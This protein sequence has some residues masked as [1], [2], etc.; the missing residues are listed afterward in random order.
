M[1]REGA[2]RLAVQAPTFFER[3]ARNEV[4][5]AKVQI[6][7]GAPV[8]SLIGGQV[9]IDQRYKQHM[10]FGRLARNEVRHDKVQIDEGHPQRA[11]REAGA[12]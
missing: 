11:F 12:R 7:R 3:L 9:R 8:P 5:P 2:S 10:F 4:W 1:T 6:N